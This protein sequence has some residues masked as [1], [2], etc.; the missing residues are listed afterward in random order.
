MKIGKPVFRQMAEAEPDYVSS[1]CPIA[2]RHIVQGMGETG[3]A[4][5]RK[6]QHPLT[7]LRMAYGLLGPIETHDDERRHATH[8][9]RQPADARGLCEGAQGVP[10]AGARAQEARAPCTWA[11][12]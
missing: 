10:R 2:G 9:P 11:S 7:L 8:H 6:E 3:A 5:P 1:D 4:A 12:T